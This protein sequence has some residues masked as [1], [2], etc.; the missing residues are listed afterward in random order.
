MPEYLVDIGGGKPAFGYSGLSANLMGMHRGNLKNIKELKDTGAITKEF[1][2]LMYNFYWIKHFRRVI[3]T[4][5]R[6]LSQNF[7]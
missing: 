3:I 2:F 6:N 7:K 4:K 5:I 1:Y